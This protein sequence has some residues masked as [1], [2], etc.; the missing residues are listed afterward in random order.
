[1]GLV[2]SLEDLCLLDILQIVNVSR[3]T[4]IL[5]LDLETGGSAYIYFLG[6][7]VQ[8]ILGVFDEGEFLQYFLDQGLVDEAEAEEAT[9]SAGGAR[10]KAVFKL[11]ESGALN[12]RLVEQARRQELAKRLKS[13]ADLEGGDFAFFLSGTGENNEAGA[14]I[15]HMPLEEPVPPQQLLSEEMTLT[16]PP[17]QVPEAVPPPAEDSFSDL[18]PSREP[19]LES[20]PIEEPV[21]QPEDLLLKESEPVFP[22]EPVEAEPAEEVLQPEPKVQEYKPKPSLQPSKNSAIIVLAAD[23]SIF[24]NLLWKRLLTHF[25]QVERV[26]TLNEYTNICMTLLDKRRPFLAVVDLLMPTQ[27]GKGYLG[28]LEILESSQVKHPEVKVILLSD[29]NDPTLL[30]MAKTKGAYLVLKKPE[31]GPLQIGQLEQ[32]IGEFAEEICEEVD[33][34]QPPVEEEVASF[35]R[36]LGAEQ[37]TE[38]YRVRDQLTLLKG[39]M[40]ELVNPHESSEISLLVLR[41]ASEYFE[42]AILFLVKKDEITGLGGFGETGDGEMMMQKVRRMKIPFDTGS[43]LDQ[44]VKDRLTILRTPEE[45][46]D[47]DRD[48]IEALGTH[49]PYEMVAI[50]MISRGRVIAILYADNAISRD[51]VTELSGIEIFMAQA[52]LAMEKTLLERQLLTLKKGI[53]AKAP[54]D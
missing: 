16:P 54:Q 6:G 15:L 41:L 32:A 26:S 2:G 53:S 43:L 14:P 3:R 52:G 38:G 31:L 42:R 21:L 17:V 46:S 49:Q 24:K 22:M 36:E 7:A 40:G 18:L 5:R 44:A 10:A 28:G 51:H 12:R 45:Q 8:E 4:G 1:M 35:F 9:A 11:L 33:R 34:I 19:L 48:F 25:A 20:P 39:L 27:D 50:P 30:D 47:V 13:L 23:D 29:L 37:V